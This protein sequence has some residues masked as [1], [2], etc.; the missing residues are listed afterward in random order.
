MQAAESP[1]L[2][3]RGATIVIRN[4]QTKEELKPQSP[5]RCR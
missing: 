5:H 2:T 4:I 1:A 3:Y